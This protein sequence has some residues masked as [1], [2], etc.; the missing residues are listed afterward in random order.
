[1]EFTDI[2]YRALAELV[3]D[4]EVASESAAKAKSDHSLLIEL[5][6]LVEQY[7]PTVLERALDRSVGRPWRKEYHKALAEFSYRH[8][9]PPNDWPL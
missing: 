5:G 3:L 8:P 9:L 4:A 7:S 1:M 6:A 2:S